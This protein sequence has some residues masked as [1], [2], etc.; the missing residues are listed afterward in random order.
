M[1][2]KPSPGPFEANGQSIELQSDYNGPAMDS[3]G[4]QMELGA[5]FLGV[6]CMVGTNSSFLI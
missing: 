5:Q 1:G 6:Q 4:S 2:I 3:P